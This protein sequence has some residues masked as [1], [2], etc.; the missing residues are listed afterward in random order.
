MALFPSDKGFP[1]RAEH[2]IRKVELP[3]QEGAI[4]FTFSDLPLGPYALVVLHDE[5]GDKDLDTNFFG[6]PTEQYGFSNNAERTFGPPSFEE[7]R[8]DVGTNPSRVEV[9]LHK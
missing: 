3:A 5:N 7:A 6:S 9:K 4:S 8:V 1:R 2:A